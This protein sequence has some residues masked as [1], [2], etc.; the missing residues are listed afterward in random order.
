MGGGGRL[1]RTTLV[2]F[3]WQKLHSCAASSTG[4]TWKNF[5]IS[6]GYSVAIA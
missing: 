4:R 2:R 5:L 1:G 3:F 6:A